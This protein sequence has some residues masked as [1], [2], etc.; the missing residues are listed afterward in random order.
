MEGWVVRVG[1]GEVG[2]EMLRERRERG[3][4]RSGSSVLSTT[5]VPSDV[6]EPLEVGLSEF[7]SFSESSSLSFRFKTS[8]LIS[9]FSPSEISAAFLA[10]FSTSPIWT[11]VNTISTVV[12]ANTAA[13]AI[14]PGIAGYFLF[15]N[16]GRHGSSREMNAVGSR[17]TNAV[18]MSTPVPK[19]RST[20]STEGGIR[21]EGKRLARRGKA[22][23]V[24]VR[25]VPWAL[26][27]GG[28]VT[29]GALEEDH[30]E[31]HDVEAFV[32]VIP[33]GTV[34]A[35]FGSRCTLVG[36]TTEEVRD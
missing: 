4:P 8:N 31:G 35:A 14:A 24:S 33:A 10:S 13:I 5:M 17:C 29:E 6:P 12:T 1:L 2:L 16:S 27:E 23:A 32:V 21:S 19:C 3:R 28:G 11:P 25:M 30:K 7:S 34:T 26:G 22:H 9:P 36:I 20:N 15:Q 18:A